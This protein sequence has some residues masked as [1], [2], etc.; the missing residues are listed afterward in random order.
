MYDRFGEE[1][2]KH[3][4]A[5]SSSTGYTFDGNP[6]Q[7]FSQMFGGS[8]PFGDLFGGSSFSFASN[9][10]GPGFGGLRGGRAPSTGFEE[11]D[12]ENAMPQGKEIQH[13]LNLTLEEL[14]QGCTKKMKIS[15]RVLSADGSLRMDEKIV[16]IVV[17]PGWKSG[18]KIRF[19]KEGDHYHGRIPADIVFVVKEKPHS[20]YK[21]DG[22]DL[23]FTSVISLKDA[24]CGFTVSVPCIDK[25][26]KSMQITEIVSPKTVK[27]LSGCGMPLSKYPGRYGD[28]IVKF[29][30]LF[31]SILKAEDKTM[32]KSILP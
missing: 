8:N 15:R 28:L 17:K 12:Y 5:D 18:R 11:M 2:L 30:I 14:H 1:G 26:V 3:G 20:V 31:P 13:D 23:T 19:P 9:L 21:R 25:M 6:H 24:L 7:L 32:L 4:G 22:N 16:E 10:S 27:R 29:D